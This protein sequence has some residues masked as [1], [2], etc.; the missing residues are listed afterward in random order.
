MKKLL[1]PDDVC[2][3]LTIEK[4]TLYAWTSKDKIPYHKLGGIR[5]EEDEIQRWLKLKKRG[6]NIDKLEDMLRAYERSKNG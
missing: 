1:T 3:L 6:L 5:F 2:D 4:S